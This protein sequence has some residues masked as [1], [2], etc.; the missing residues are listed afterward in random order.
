VRISYRLSRAD[1][2][3]GALLQ[4][5]WLRT[6]LIMTVSF[7]AVMAATGYGTIPQPRSAAV[8]VRWVALNGTGSLVFG[9]SMAL[10][11]RFLLLPFNIWRLH[12]QNPMMYG[13]MELI[14]EAEGIEV[15]SARSTVK[16]AWHELRG[17][18]END[19]VFLL[20]IS[21]SVGF[22]VPKRDVPADTVTGLRALL[23]ERLTRLK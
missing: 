12:R 22:P 10:A 16:F 7:F 9:L 3:Q 6:V 19:A 1:L 13:D 2:L 11:F 15:K 21:K 18:K 23:E 17:F 14:A 5:N 20:S 8:L 4:T